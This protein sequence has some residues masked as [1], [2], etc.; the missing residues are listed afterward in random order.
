MD[1][2]VI[3][4]TALLYVIRGILEF[5]NQE[6]MRLAP[7]NISY[8]QNQ[9]MDKLQDVDVLKNFSDQA[10]LQNTVHGILLDKMVMGKWKSHR[11][12]VT[13]V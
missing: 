3:L 8:V 13:L 7:G 11:N 10:L 1:I 4:Q 12:R 5:L 6:G 9:V 2:L